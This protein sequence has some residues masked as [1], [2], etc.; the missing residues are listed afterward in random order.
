MDANGTVG[1]LKLTDV[2]FFGANN[3]RA[4]EMNNVMKEFD[5]ETCRFFLI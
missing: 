5:L 1:L 4:M 2:Q 3:V